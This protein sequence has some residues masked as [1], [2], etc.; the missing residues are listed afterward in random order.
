MTRKEFWTRFE[1]DRSKEAH[2][3]L[4][5]E[6]YIQFATDRTR[7]LVENTIGV[8]RIKA[9]TDPHFNDIPLGEWDRM[10][11]RVRDT[12]DRAKLGQAEPTGKPG[13]FMW[14]LSTA[15]CV[16]KAVAREIRDAETNDDPLDDFNY[17]GSRHHY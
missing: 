14:S 9:S 12:I 15:V 17:V 5:H 16:A 3:A 13:S 4:H 1:A 10:E 6:Y 7:R 11:M 2:E 8:D